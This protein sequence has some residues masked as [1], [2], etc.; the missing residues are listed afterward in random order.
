M[1]R[2]PGKKPLSRPV[3][4]P[5]CVNASCKIHCFVPHH[6][7]YMHV[8][9]FRHAC[10]SPFCTTPRHVRVTAVTFCTDP[11]ATHAPPPLHFHLGPISHGPRLSMTQCEESWPARPFAWMQRRLQKL[12][13]SVQNIKCGHLKKKSYKWYNKTIYSL[14]YISSQ[15]TILYN[16][17]KYI[18]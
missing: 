18:K 12:G 15:C 2:V 17:Q 14:Y 13:A 3:P 7:T 5:A 16:I 1:R 11:L 9:T 10:V 8:K 6:A 4:S